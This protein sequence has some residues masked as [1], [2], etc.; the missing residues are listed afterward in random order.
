MTA[1]AVPPGSSELPEPA[2]LAGLAGRRVAIWGFGAE[3][4]STLAALRCR[5]PEQPVTIL[6]DG[7]P[8]PER[9]AEIQGLAGVELITGPAALAALPGFEVVVKA[10]GISPHTGRSA[11]ALAEARAAAL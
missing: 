7:E 4:R 3:G 11:R 1:A 8:A 2:G 5:L 9:L 6:D 10:P